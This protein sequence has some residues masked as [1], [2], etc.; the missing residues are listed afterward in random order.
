MSDVGNPP[1]ATVT[2]GDRTA[3]LPI[4]TG[5]EGVPSVDFSTFTKQTGHTSLDYGF[6][7]TAATKSAIDSVRTNDPSSPC[8]ASRASVL[9]TLRLCRATV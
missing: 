7:N 1:K 2:V 3:E 6:V 9:P 4:L 8:S 5:T